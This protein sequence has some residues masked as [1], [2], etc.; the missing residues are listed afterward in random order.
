MRAAASKPRSE[1]WFAHKPARAVPR[2]RPV[3]TTGTPFPPLCPRGEQNIGRAPQRPTQ[4][5]VSYAFAP[6]KPHGQR[7]RVYRARGSATCVRDYLEKKGR[8]RRTRG[9]RPLRPAPPPRIAP[10][11]PATGARRTPR[12]SPVAARRAS[13]DGRRRGPPRSARRRCSA[14]GGSEQT[15][16]RSSQG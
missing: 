6:R 16:A 11:F 12:S 15:S 10:A 3:L 2:R 14:T 9:D 5:V 7:R 8:T 4:C 1:S 13:G